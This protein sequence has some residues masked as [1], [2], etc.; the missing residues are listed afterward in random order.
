MDPGFNSNHSCVARSQTDGRRVLISVF[1]NQISFYQ[2]GATSNVVYQ[3]NTVYR[4]S[5]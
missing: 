5:Q 1:E 4:S 3:I 2:S